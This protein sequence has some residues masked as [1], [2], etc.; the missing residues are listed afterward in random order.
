MA[1]QDG[2]RNAALI[3]ELARA[4]SRFNFYRAVQLI[5]GTRPDAVPVGEIGPAK[6]EALRFVHDPSFAFHASDVS[7]VRP[8]VV[9]DGVSFVEIESTFFGLFGTASPL[10]AYISEEILHAEDV[11]DHSLRAF[12]DVFHHRLLSL[13]FRAWKK[14]RFASG[15]RADATDVFTRRAMAFV[16]VD[17]RAMPREGLGALELLAIAPLLSIRTRPARSLQIILERMV[18]GTVIGVESFVAR[19]VKLA[20]DQVMRLGKQSSSLGVD[21]TLG[22]SVIDRSGRFR[23]AVGPVDYE[24][25]DKLMPGGQRHPLL[26]NVI[27]QFSRGVLEAEC[28]ITLAAEEVP[29]LQLGMSR[30][31]KLG[32]TTTLR[33]RVTEP[34]HARFVLSPE[35]ATARA[36]LL[37]N[38]SAPSTVAPRVITP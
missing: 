13:L 18:P 25:F 23:V 33:G 4:P 28:Q 29:R 5:E 3:A 37:D 31:S 21:T 16:G 20:P 24:T 26:R 15:F 34:I 11:D 19:R 9:R 6:R 14:N 32:V 17:A 10:A 1:G 12:Y 22:S 7:A 2:E 27:H 36:T 30:G 38:E 35:A 8:Q